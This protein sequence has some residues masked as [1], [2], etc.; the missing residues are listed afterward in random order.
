MEF[1][2]RV[3]HNLEGVEFF[4]V[5]ACPGCEECGLA[6]VDDMD[7]PAYELAGE[8]YFSWQD[9]DSCGSSL[10]GDRHPAHGF[11]DGELRHFQ[12]CTDC[13][14]YHANGDLP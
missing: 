3:A 13:L 8:S 9:C 12:V 7:N 11:I 14:M 6:D 2:E 10:G 1:T 4:S 5:G